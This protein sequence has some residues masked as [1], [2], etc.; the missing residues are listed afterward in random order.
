VAWTD[1]PPRL[2]D[3]IT[4]FIEAATNESFAEALLTLEL[5]ANDD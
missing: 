1:L 4:A 3:S 2:K 5:E